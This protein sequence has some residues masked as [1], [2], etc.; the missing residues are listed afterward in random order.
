MHVRCKKFSKLLE[1]LDKTTF[2]KNLKLEHEISENNKALDHRSSILRICDKSHKK[3][4]NRF[5]Y[6]KKGE[7]GASFNSCRERISKKSI[8]RKT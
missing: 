6:K 8:F 7:R 1:I 2:S 5:S 3:N 4:I